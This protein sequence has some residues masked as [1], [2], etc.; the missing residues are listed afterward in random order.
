MIFHMNDGF[1]PVLWGSP[2][3]YVANS[4]NRL[5]DLIFQSLEAHLACFVDNFILPASAVDQTLPIRARRYIP[6]DLVVR[7]ETKNCVPYICSS[8]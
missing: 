1:V 8:R 7:F 4:A 6:K 2:Y 3:H 5:E